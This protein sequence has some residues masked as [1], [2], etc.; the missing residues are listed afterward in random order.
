[1]TLLATAT[2]VLASSSETRRKLLENA[3]VRLEVIVPRVDETE[4]KQSMIHDAAGADEL[5]EVLAEHKA[6][7][8]SR[9]RPEDLVIGADQILDCEGTIYSKPVDRDA[10]RRQLLA[11]R[12]R[13]HDLVSCVCVVRQGERLWHSLDRAH[14]R[15]RNFSDSFIDQYLDA[16]GNTALDSPGGY[17]VEGLGAQL[18]DRIS[19]SHFTILGLPLI[20]LLDYLRVQ[21]ALSL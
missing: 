21:G 4:I 7:Y 2:I 14:L 18:F 20:P 16:V 5:A 13:D 3:G 8:V 11:L 9:Q 12:G 1:M 10:A 17:R 6:R 19:G 15:M